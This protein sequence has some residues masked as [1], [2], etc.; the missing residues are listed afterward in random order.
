MRLL[1][2]W[3]SRITLWFAR[4]PDSIHLSKPP[5]NLTLSHYLTMNTTASNHTI[6]ALIAHVVSECSTVDIEESFVETLD[7]EGEVNVCGLTLM[8]SQIWKECDPTAFR[9]GVADHSDSMDVTE[10]EGDYYQ[11]DD[12]EKA[13][14][15]FVD[16]L[17][18][19]LRELEDTLSN[20]EEDG[21][22]DD[23]I[24]GCKAEIAKLETFISEVERHSF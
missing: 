13:R 22:G 23:E 1:N 16:G 20:H 24:E 3:V 18:D 4:I 6:A 15:E 17:N 7:S 9:C 12:I 5:S 19:E 2:A 10:I 8:P 11:N 14:E 21:S